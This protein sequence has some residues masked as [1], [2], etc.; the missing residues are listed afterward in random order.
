MHFRGSRL[1]ACREPDAGEAEADKEEDHGDCKSPICGSGNGCVLLADT[2]VT[3]KLDK[4]GGAGRAETTATRVA[5]CGCRSRGMKVAIH[6][7]FLRIV[8]NSLRGLAGDSASGDNPTDPAQP[9]FAR[10]SP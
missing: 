8:H 2:A 4:S 6:L 1:G 9:Q 5:G 3:A 10:V 7:A